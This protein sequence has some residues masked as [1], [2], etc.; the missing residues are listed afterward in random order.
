M[1]EREE[2]A[3]LPPELVRA[4]V[5]ALVFASPEPVTP[6][7]IGSILGE[8][9]PRDSWRDAL[10]QLGEEYA[11]DGSGLQL[12][13]VAGGYQITTRPDL[14][15]WVR[16]LVDPKAPTRLSIQALET[17]AVIAYK[18]PT[19]LPE[20]IEL[21]GVKSAGVVKTLLE[22][23]LIKI[24]GRKPVVGRPILY[25]TSKQFLLQFGLKN[26]KELPEIE[27]F[28]QVLGEEVDVAGLKRA[29]E[30]PQPTDA[31]VEEAEPGAADPR[32]A[33]EPENA[34]SPAALAAP[35]AETAQE[36]EA[37]AT[38]PIPEPEPNPRNLK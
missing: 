31:A 35:A 27:E 14:N 34:A 38:E 28:A 16:E 36:P 17:L 13:E 33:P 4:I 29:I 21:R 5:E 9:V 3:A 23:R 25:G 30:A 20:I 15:D 26:V 2:A 11:Q 12:I 18:Q 24:V 22:K 1:S 37:A 19:T 32:D 8:A 6:R 7:Q 10:K